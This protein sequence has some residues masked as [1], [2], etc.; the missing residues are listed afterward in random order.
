[1]SEET[2]NP[3]SEAAKHNGRLGGLTSGAKRRAAKGEDAAPIAPPVAFDES[4]MA[5]YRREFARQGGLKGGVARGAKLSKERKQEI[6]R[7]G[8]LARWGKHL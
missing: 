4:Q 7:M 6:G 2:P 1:M 3:V 5:A 8:G